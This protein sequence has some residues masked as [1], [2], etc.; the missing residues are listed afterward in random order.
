M[1]TFEPNKQYFRRGTDAA[2]LPAMVKAVKAAEA[3]APRPHAGVETGAA[4][5]VL[6]PATALKD[7]TWEIVRKS[8]V[9]K[10][11][12]ILF[13]GV[14]FAESDTRIAES[15]RFSSRRGGKPVDP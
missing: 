7:R 9:G 6:G 1:L 11:P 4:N 5:G 12:G 10:A 13:R 3:I 14:E 8:E 2:N 15:L